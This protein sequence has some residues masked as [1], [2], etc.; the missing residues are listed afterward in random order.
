MT[1]LITDAHAFPECGTDPTTHREAVVPIATVSGSMTK[2]SEWHDKYLAV[3]SE[4]NTLLQVRPCKPTRA[5]ALT[6]PGGGGGRGCSS[7]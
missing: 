3:Q 2:S 4:V 6:P 7:C 1:V 5:G